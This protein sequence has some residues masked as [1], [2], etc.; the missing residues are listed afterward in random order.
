[1]NT[2]PGPDVQMLEEKGDIPDVKEFIPDPVALAKQRAA[3][4]IAEVQIK[5]D[6]NLHAIKAQMIADTNPTEKAYNNMA[7]AQAP[8]KN[9]KKAFMSLKRRMTTFKYNQAYKRMGFDSARNLF[10]R[11][12]FY[13][14]RRY[15]PIPVYPKR[16]FYRAY[17]RYP[18]AYT[19]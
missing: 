19:R 10:R 16:K 13:R 5:R 8:K 1:M 3:I 4:D 17:R 7:K 18:S 6:A 12:Q 9:W 14:R 2:L 11:R 15:I